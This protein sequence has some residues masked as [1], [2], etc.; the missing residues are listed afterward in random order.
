[1]NT[2]L[3]K[4]DRPYMRYQYFLDFPHHISQFLQY[5][6]SGYPY[7]LKVLITLEQVN[8]SV[9]KKQR[10]FKTSAKLW[11]WGWLV[12]VVNFLCS[13]CDD[14]AGFFFLAMVEMAHHVHG[15]FAFWEWCNFSQ[16][17]ALD[18]HVFIHAYSINSETNR[19][20]PYKK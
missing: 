11:W 1:M 20:I 14:D 15:I 5:S 19:W 9:V 7:R 10:L 3:H 8:T 4:R 2:T 12:G 17:E 18:F 6:S 13:K 16:I